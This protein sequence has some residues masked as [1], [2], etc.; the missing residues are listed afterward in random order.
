LYEKQ[1]AIEKSNFLAGIHRNLSPED[2]ATA[3][4]ELE[5]VAFYSAVL[6]LRNLT[7]STA[8]VVAITSEALDIY[9]Q[10]SVLRGLSPDAATD[11]ANRYLRRFDEYDSAAQERTELWMMW[12]A[13]KAVE[14]CYGLKKNDLGTT[15]DM[16]VFIGF[17]VKTLTEV[18]VSMIYQPLT[19]AAE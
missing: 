4:S 11:L 16:V 19:H 3:E 9:R 6:V 18:M 10:A 2:R 8:M 1:T 5:I 14:R 15:S 7:P 12:V 13:A 17:F